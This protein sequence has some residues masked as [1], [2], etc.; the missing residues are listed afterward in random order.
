VRVLRVSHSGVISA[1]RQRERELSTLGVDVTLATA[2]RWNEGGAEVSFSADADEF[3]V[4]V[5]TFGRHPN[6]FVF[7]PRPLWRLLGK[8]WDILDIHEEPCSLATA[9]LLVLRS[10]RARGIPFLLYSAQNLLKRYPP[11]FRWVERWALARAAGAYV[12]NTEAGI[13]LRGKGLRGELRE[14]PL[15]VDTSLFAPSEHAPPSGR[16]RIGYVGRLESHKGVDSLIGAMSGIAGAT[17]DIIG[18][19]PEA[20]A[21]ASSASR[22]GLADRV[23]FRGFVD[24]GDLPDVYRS[25]DVVAVPSLPSPGWLE[26]FCRV[27]VEAMA[28][29]IPVVVSD[30][31]A[32]P[33]VVG[34]GG[35]LIPPGNTDA[36][37]AALQRLLDEPELWS[38]LRRAALDR[39]PSFSWPAVAKAHDHLYE[40]V[41]PT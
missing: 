11:P 22:L 9:E 39:A 36:W 5:R 19:G 16:L 40:D 4:P 37:R 28:S 34:G 38:S 21:L 3:A 23:T 18:A 6:I 13:I 14:I 29:G 20:G 32:L 26:Q 31:G 10:L 30:T 12:C 27:A 41:A 7:D 33:E 2:R 1:W 24:Q 15:G 25:F 17:L 35:L 8:S